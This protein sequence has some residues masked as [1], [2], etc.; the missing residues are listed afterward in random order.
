MRIGIDIGPR[1]HA[2]STECL[3]G[4][5]ARSVAINRLG[6]AATA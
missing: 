6:R 2:I 1:Y 4:L 3:R 5:V